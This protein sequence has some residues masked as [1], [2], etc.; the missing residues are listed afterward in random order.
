[1]RIYE[2]RLSG[3]APNRLEVNGA[4]C[5][6]LKRVGFAQLRMYRITLDFPDAVLILSLSFPCIVQALLCQGQ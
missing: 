2:N 3:S 5:N 1:M 6:L 4:D